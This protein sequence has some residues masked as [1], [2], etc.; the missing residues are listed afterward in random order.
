MKRK[1][2]KDTGPFTL[3]VEHVPPTA[4]QTERVGE[5][6][7]ILATWLVRHHR[8]KVAEQTAL[9]SGSKQAPLSEH[10]EATSGT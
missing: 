4:Q 2:S 8:R 9:T 10:P 1:P 6:L 3:E 7:R 5:G